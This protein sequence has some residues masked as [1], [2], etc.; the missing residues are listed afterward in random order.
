MMH[1]GAERISA[2]Y[3]EIIGYLSQTPMP[4]SPSDIFSTNASW[5]RYNQAV[6]DLSTI[7]GADYSRFQIQP[8]YLDGEEIVYIENYRQS[9]NGL[10]NTLHALYFENKPAPFGASPTTVISQAQFQVQS[11]QMLLDIQ[12]K[13]DM[14]LH[15]LHEDSPKKRFLEKLKSGLSD[16]KNVTEFMGLLLKLAKDFNLSMNDLTSIFT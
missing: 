12:S 10:I 13:I 5:K 3:G 11:V 7:T 1:P 8:E 6:Q 14:N 16:I 4:S 2:I 15:S 9:L